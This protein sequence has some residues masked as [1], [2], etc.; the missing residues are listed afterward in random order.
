MTK[1]GSILPFLTV[2]AVIAFC[3]Q[4]FSA[5]QADV[6]LWGNVF[7]VQAPAWAEGF[8]RINTF[9]FTDPGH[10]WINHE[11][12]A[13]YGFHSVYRLFGNAGL[14]GLKVL[15]GL[16]IIGLMNRA[17]RKECRSGVVRFLWL[18]LIISVMGFGFNTRPHL[19]TFLMTAIFLTLLGRSK[20]SPWLVL[21]IP[22]LGLIWVNLH[23]AFFIG[24]I[25]L[26]I[27]LVGRGVPPSRLTEGRNLA[28]LA[29]ALTLFMGVTFVTLWRCALEVRG[30][31][32]RNG[33][34]IPDGVGSV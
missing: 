23:G 12:L 24:L 28:V 5:N 19:F 7:F 30:R 10:D 15:L 22:L 27:F 26:G 18:M 32:S 31:I 3:V 34:A 2:S 1:P 33:A 9:S 4:I 13:Q 17:I 14:I 21:W 29:G 11:W 16:L 20:F 25:I 6:D 8:H